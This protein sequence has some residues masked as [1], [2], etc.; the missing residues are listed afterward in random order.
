MCCGLA[1]RTDIKRLS[2]ELG[3]DVSLLWV[4]PCCAL[5]Q[6]LCVDTICPS[7]VENDQTL[8]WNDVPFAHAGDGAAQIDKLHDMCHGCLQDWDN[9]DW[10]KDIAHDEQVNSNKNSSSSINGA[11]K[12][13]AQDAM[14]DDDDFGDMIVDAYTNDAPA[15]QSA[16]QGS[17]VVATQEALAD[18]S[19]R[20]CTSIALASCQQV[21]LPNLLS[22]VCEAYRQLGDAEGCL[23]AAAA[24]AKLTRSHSANKQTEDSMLGPVSA[25][26]CWTS[27]SCRAVIRLVERSV[28][29]LHHSVVEHVQACSGI[30]LVPVAQN[31]KPLFTHA[32]QIHSNL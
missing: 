28:V 17:K 5:A 27:T 21:L 8:C 29:I 31:R 15:T 7:Q 2:L 13:S 25:Y 30:G 32:R 14:L 23:S 18:E 20:L 22:F 11:A 26:V 6:L 10:D 16:V 4:S 9:G 19:A 3:V 1:L 24:M 12:R